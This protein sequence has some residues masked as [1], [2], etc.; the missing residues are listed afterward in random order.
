VPSRFCC[1]SLYNSLWYA[2]HGSRL[3]H[4][5]DTHSVPTPHLD[6]KH[7]VFGRVRSN[8]ALVRRIEALPTTSD[9]P[10]EDVTIVSAG[11]L[12]P[13]DLAKE[14]QDKAAAQSGGDDVWEE[15]PEDEEGVDTEV[16]EKALEVAKKLKELGTK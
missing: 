8:R 7:V 13:E 12:T 9:K 14:E 4:T 11:V 6:G 5:T 15:Y 3:L 2:Q 1:D 16:P 10:H